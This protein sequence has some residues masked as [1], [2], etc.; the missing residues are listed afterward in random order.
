MVERKIKKNK[1]HEVIYDPC[2]PA[3]FS[4]NK[5]RLRVKKKK[6]KG[7]GTID[8]CAILFKSNNKVIE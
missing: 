7:G 1:E 6:K 4:Q 8:R 2:V 3:M 5:I